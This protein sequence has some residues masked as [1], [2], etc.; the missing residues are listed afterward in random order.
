MI[1]HCLLKIELPVLQNPC[2]W[3]LGSDRMDFG[4]SGKDNHS[5]RKTAYTIQLE[6]S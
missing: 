5:K 2:L 3:F 6:R 1:N 4:E